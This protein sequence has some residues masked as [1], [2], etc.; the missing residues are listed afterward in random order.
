[1][2]WKGAAL[3]RWGRVDLEARAGG[4]SLVVLVGPDAWVA[5][6]VVVRLR[7][8]LMLRSEEVQRLQ[9]ERQVGSRDALSGAAARRERWRT[10]S[11]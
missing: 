6:V 3:D 7:A 5:V 9:V 1:M 4:R 10:A 2:V 8:A 11:S